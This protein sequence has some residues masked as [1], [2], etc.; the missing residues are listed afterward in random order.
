MAACGSV[1]GLATSAHATPGS[2]ISAVLLAEGKAEDPIRIRTHGNT[3]TVVRKITVQPGGTTGWHYH[4]GQLLAVVVSGTLSHYDRK[5]RR[6]DHSQGSSFLEVSGAREVH[7]G[8]NEGTEP[9]ELV[10]TYVNPAGAPLAQ[11][12]PAPKCAAGK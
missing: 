7:M 6:S 5:C 10:V 2:G 9:V 1:L 11:D 8:T 3:N 4:D 12:A